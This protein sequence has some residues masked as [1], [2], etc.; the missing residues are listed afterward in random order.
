MRCT[1]PT[2][3][4]FRTLLVTTAGIGCAV[5]C[6][7]SSS[8]VGLHSLGWADTNRPV[9]ISAQRSVAVAF[10]PARDGQIDAV[11]LVASRYRGQ[12]VGLLAYVVT[13]DDPSTGAPAK[14]VAA[15]AGTEPGC[16]G[17][18]D[19]R[20]IVR[21][22]PGADDRGKRLPG[23]GRPHLLD[24]VGDCSRRGGS[25][26]APGYRNPSS[27]H[28]AQ[29]P[30]TGCLLGASRRDG[31]TRSLTRHAPG[32]SLAR[33][34]EGSGAQSAGPEPSVTVAVWLCPALS[35]QPIVTDWPGW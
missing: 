10:T 23:A 19:G 22:A 26:S 12:P 20:G 18:G 21:D 7:A 25:V 11:N 4:A 34:P 33:K 16:S 24:S 17:L 14:P 3:K 30:C 6:A 27:G 35:T 29:P 31:W 32:G 1:R 15:P 8:R 9:Q 13:P 5:S 2:A 28:D